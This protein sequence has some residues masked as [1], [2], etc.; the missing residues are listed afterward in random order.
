MK[1]GDCCSLEKQGV[2]IQVI[3]FDDKGYKKKLFIKGQISILVDDSKPKCTQ[4]SH[5]LR[6]KFK[7]K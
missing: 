1:N 5:F 7:G 4:L 2:R 3:M 6:T